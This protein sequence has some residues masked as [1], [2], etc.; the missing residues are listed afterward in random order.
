[1]EEKHPGRGAPSFPCFARVRAS[2]EKSF[3]NVAYG[4]GRLQTVGGHWHCIDT[5]S[6]MLVQSD[7]IGYKQSQF[8][9]T[10]TIVSMRRGFWSS[11]YAQLILL[12]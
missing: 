4:G 10:L 3:S 8:E 6:D 5:C 12:V 7:G 9:F 2:C 11:L 1:M